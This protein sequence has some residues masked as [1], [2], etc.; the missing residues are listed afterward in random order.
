MGIHINLTS[1]VY[2]GLYQCDWLANLVN[3]LRI[4]CTVKMD[5]KK[6]RHFLPCF[7]IIRL[8]S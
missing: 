3:L 8:Q 4:V 1:L 5:V 6:V 2:A 7:I